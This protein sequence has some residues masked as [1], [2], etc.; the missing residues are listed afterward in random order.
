MGTDMPSEAAKPEREPSAGV[1]VDQGLSSLGLLMQLG[2]S[3][4]AAGGA[5]SILT[6]VF[7]MQGRDRDLLP[8]ILVLGL[9]IVRSLV[10]RIAG[11]ELLYGKYLDA[12]GIAKNPLFGMRRYVVV[13]LAQTA[14]IAFIALAKFDIPVQTVIGLVLALLAWP[15]A[16]GVLLQ[17]ARFQRYRISIP[18]SEDKGFEGAAIVMT[19]LGLSGVLATGL[20]L[21]VTF[22]RDDHALTQG[23]GVL[24]MLAMIMLV[25]RSGL[26]LQAGLSGLRETSIDRSVE[27]ANRYA[28]FGVISSFCTAGSL[29]LLAMTSSMGLANLSVVAALVWA[30]VTW[31]LIIR[32]FFSDRQFADLL[33]GDNASAHRR[34]PDAGLT[35][36][37]WLLV[38]FATVLAMLLIPQLVSEARILGVSQQSEL[39]SFAGPISDRSIWWNV[40]LTMLMLWTGIELL[41]MSRSHRIVGIVYGVV[42]T[43]V[44][45]YV[46]W[47]A[48][49]AFRQASTWGY[50]V[51]AE[52]SLLLVLPTMTLQLVLP[53]ATLLLVTRKITPTAR[54]RFR[55]KVAKPDAVDP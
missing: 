41:R 38:G 2:G 39:L 31:P 24:L 48:I 32:R 25:I 28:N 34:A 42:G 4:A 21:F 18:V 20:V 54:A 51:I 53:I 16:L 26:H 14:I 36:L 3:L 47:P 50:S 30:L 12:D 29:L 43:L 23:P 7:A 46:F 19:V 8:L 40:G 45:L 15:V 6:I 1:P 17:T 52:P 35:S 49:S 9:C 22:D 11:T 33:A 5:L 27:L 37:G 10:L 13:A 55:V 44:T